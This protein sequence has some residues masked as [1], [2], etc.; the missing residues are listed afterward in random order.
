MTNFMDTT[1]NYDNI[2]AQNSLA[3]FVTVKGWDRWNSQ[4]DSCLCTQ[5]YVFLYLLNLKISFLHMTTK[6]QAMT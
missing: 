1:L 2:L 3:F 4:I 5:L 6:L